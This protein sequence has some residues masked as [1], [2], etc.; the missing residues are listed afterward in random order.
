[1]IGV[2]ETVG[3]VET[4]RMCE[5]HPAKCFSLGSRARAIYSTGTCRRTVPLLFPFPSL[6]ILS[7]SLSLSFLPSRCWKL[8]GHLSAAPRKCRSN[9]CTSARLIGQVCRHDVRPSFLPSFLPFLSASKFHAP[10]FHL[11]S[12]PDYGARIMHFLPTPPTSSRFVPRRKEDSR[13]LYRSKSGMKNDNS[14]KW[15]YRC[16]NVV[17]GSAL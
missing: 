16:W 14:G 2:G 10:F 15:D 4:S 5:R 13:R 6:R 3:G 17:A 1:M 12:N 7:L 9:S 11:S 8:P